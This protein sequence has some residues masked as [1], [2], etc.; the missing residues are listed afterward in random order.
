MSGPQG[1]RKTDWIWGDGE[2]KLVFDPGGRVSLRKFP[3]PTEESTLAASLFWTL[4]PGAWLDDS[5]TRAIEIKKLAEAVYSYLCTDDQL[6][7][8]KQL[9]KLTRALRT[10]R[11]HLKELHTFRL[12]P[13]NKDRLRKLWLTKEIPEEHRAI[14]EARI[15]EAKPLKNEDEKL[16]QS[17]R[18]LAEELGRPPFPSELQKKYKGSDFTDLKRRVKKAGLGQLPKKRKGRASS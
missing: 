8:E 17:V 3:Q 13:R 18:I 15:E 9:E 10:A 14:I 11:D 4:P 5:R 2:W 16:R 12:D 6:K 7:S 1:S